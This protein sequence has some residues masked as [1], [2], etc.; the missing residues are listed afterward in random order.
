M[1]GISVHLR[2]FG[3]TIT[4]GL[5]LILG[6]WMITILHFDLVSCHDSSVGIIA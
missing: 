6:G 3:Y 1:E 4:A 2:I 5:I